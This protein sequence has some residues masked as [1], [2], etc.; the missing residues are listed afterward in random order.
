MFLQFIDFSILHTN[1]LPVDRGS[2]ICRKGV[3]ASGELQI[4][5][6]GGEAIFQLEVT[7]AINV[8]STPQSPEC[9]TI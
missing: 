2:G 6:L 7:A 5:M 9:Q 8:V 4:L 3:H 1:H